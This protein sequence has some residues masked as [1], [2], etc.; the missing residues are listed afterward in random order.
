M[1][2]VLIKCWPWPFYYE[3]FVI[4]SIKNTIANADI[5]QL[6][7]WLNPPLSGW[8]GS[9]YNSKNSKWIPFYFNRY[10]KMAI[11]MRNS[12]DCRVLEFPINDSVLGVAILIVLIM[13][14]SWIKHRRGCFIY[15]DNPIPL[16]C[17]YRIIIRL[18]TYLIIRNVSRFLVIQI[19][20]DL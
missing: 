15:H 19:S 16:I 4:W 18:W 17:Y 11:L 9:H 20:H 5:F 7:G 1:C 13:I 8:G 12:N 14:Q 6:C 10:R 2:Q 3:H